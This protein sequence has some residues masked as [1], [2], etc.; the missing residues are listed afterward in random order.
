MRR[1]AGT[2]VHTARERG[3]ER[4][5]LEARE[6]EKAEAGRHEREEWWLIFSKLQ[7]NQ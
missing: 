4:V 1:H 3:R 5:A 7:T 2:L 6:R